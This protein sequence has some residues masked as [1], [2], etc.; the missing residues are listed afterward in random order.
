VIHGRYL[1]GFA[2]GPSSSKGCWLRE[3]FAAHWQSYEIPELDGGD[4]YHLTI[5]AM[6]ERARV[7][8]AALPD[9]GAPLLLIGS[10]LGGFCAAKLAAD[11]FDRPTALL[12]LAPAFGFTERWR[13][14][15]GESGL[16]DWRRQGER[17]F[18][19]HVYR[20][21]RPL[22]SAFLESCEQ[23]PELPPPSRV[24]TVTVHGRRDQSVDWR[25]SRLYAERAASARLEL[26]EDE[27]ALMAP[28]SQALT[29]ASVEDLMRIINDTCQERSQS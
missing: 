29:A 5:D 27:H 23:L 2:S 24:P 7:S 10:S 17:A 15:L 12:L 3:R 20:E 6:V 1:H 9:D 8:V 18:F 19:H 14:L 26:V 4:F 13:A 16:A 11:G 28:E 21:E 22:A 25:W